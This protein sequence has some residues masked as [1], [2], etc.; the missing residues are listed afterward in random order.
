MIDGSRSDTQF[1]GG[2]FPGFP[3]AGFAGVQVIEGNRDDLLRPGLLGKSGD[4]LPINGTLLTI[5]EGNDGGLADS[6]FLGCLLTGLPGLLHSG[7][8]VIEGDRHFRTTQFLGLRF[9]HS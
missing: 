5:D 7:F 9:T 2:S 8:L 1:L 6:E 4:P 3:M